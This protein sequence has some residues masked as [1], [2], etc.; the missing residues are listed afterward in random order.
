MR[1]KEKR[2]AKLF[3]DKG[4]ITPKQLKEAL[5]D[6][7]KTGETLGEIFERKGW[8]NLSDFNKA[9]DLPQVNVFNA[10]SYIVDPEAVGLIPEDAASIYK[11][12]PVTKK[13]DTLVVAAVDPNNKSTINELVR[14]TGLR[15]ETIAA[16]ERDLRRAQEQFYGGKDKL[17]GILSSADRFHLKQGEKI[18]EEA[19]VIKLV[20]FLLKEA[21]RV[22]ASDIHIEPE[23]EFLGVRYRIDGILHHFTFLPKALER[24]IVSRFKVMAGLDITEKRLPQEGHI[25]MK[26]SP[27]E[28]DFRLSTFPGTSGENVVIRVLD[29][30]SVSMEIESLGIPSKDLEGFSSLIQQPYGIVLVTGPTGSGKTTTL[31]SALQRLNREDINIMTIEDPVEYEF[32]RIRQFQIY[33]K[34]GLNFATALR[35]FLRQDPDVIMVGEIRDFETAEIAVQAALTGHLVLSSLHTNNAPAAFNRLLNMKIEPF[36]VSTAVKG[37]LAQRLVRKICPKCKEEY[38]PSLSLLKSLNLDEKIDSK[39]KF[40]RGTGCS[41]CY[42]TGYKGRTGIYELLRVTP[43]IQSLI[44]EKPSSG[45]IRKLAQAQGMKTLRES[46]IKKL[47]YG[48]TSAD[49]VLRM[50][51]QV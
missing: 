4:V 49:E 18:G 23:E 42:N 43:Q 13:G 33:P 50:T 17:Q 34:I 36:L 2:V 20:D 27:K 40:M 26:I 12:V 15:I 5:S 19:S 44:L 32:P 45:D 41:F 1:E 31:Y 16:D 29:R 21:V 22:A 6:Q 37:V 51:K 38:T 47:F 46:A 48:I 25:M 11:V 24:S 9:L 30:S 10:S 3:V 8:F 28:I 39:V 35:S 14:M 7:E